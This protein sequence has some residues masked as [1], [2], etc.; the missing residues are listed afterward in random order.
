MWEPSWE[1]VLFKESSS[2]SKISKKSKKRHS[3]DKDSSDESPLDGFFNAGSDS[4]DS[5]SQSHYSDDYEEDKDYD[6]RLK[7]DWRKDH[8]QGP[9]GVKVKKLGKKHTD[10]KELR[11]TNLLFDKVVL[12]RLYLLKNKSR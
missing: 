8:V 5:S 9:V 4:D 11:L 2:K 10:L 3:D 6:F 7:S 1:E 12:Y